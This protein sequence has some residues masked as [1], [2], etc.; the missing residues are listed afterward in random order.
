MPEIKC[1]DANKF[2]RCVTCDSPC[3]SEGHFIEEEEPVKKDGGVIEL[4]GLTKEEI[5]KLE[6]VKHLIINEKDF[7]SKEYAVDLCTRFYVQR[8]TEFDLSKLSAE[9]KTWRKETGC[10]ASDEIVQFVISKL[11]K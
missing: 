1:G 9:L 6:T 2:Y 10:N 8:L 7:V 3:G 11:I 5:E 4:N